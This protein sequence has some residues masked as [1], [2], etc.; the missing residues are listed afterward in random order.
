MLSHKL[1]ML[2]SIGTLNFNNIYNL[3]NF[4]LFYRI[5]KKQMLQIAKKTIYFGFSSSLILDNAILDNN[6]F[7][8]KDLSKVI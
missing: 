3:F 5:D 7:N 8:K 1:L 6:D 2:S 4:K